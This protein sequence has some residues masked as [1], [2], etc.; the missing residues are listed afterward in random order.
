MASSDTGPTSWSHTFLRMVYAATHLPIQDQIIPKENAKPVISRLRG[1]LYL[2]LNQLQLAKQS[3]MEALAL[4]VRNFDV[5]LEL[6]NSMMTVEEE[7]HF[8]QNL[9]YRDQL[10][11]EDAAFNHDL[12]RISAARQLLADHYNLEENADMRFLDAERSFAA[13]DWDACYTITSSIL[14]EIPNHISALPLHLACL[15]QLPRL[16]SS[17][18]MLAHRL[19]REQPLSF[20][21]WYA[22]GLWYF[23]GHNWAE[24]RRYFA[25]SLSWVC[26]P[27][28]R[29]SAFTNA[30][31]LFVDGTSA[32]LPVMCIGMEYIQLNDMPMAL[33]A[34]STA[35]SYG[36]ED[37]L[38]FNEIGI[39]HFNQEQLLQQSYQYPLGLANL[40]LHAC[41]NLL[42]HG[43][44]SKKIQPGHRALKLRTV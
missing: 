14:R 37:P 25:A 13:S 17:L 39:V 36:V 1:I 20:V 38:L 8:I 30:H 41:R 11:S 16:A 32:Y 29:L 43:A 34:L 4:D 22:V 6:T 31:S 15:T 18:F 40:S 19:V 42:Q 21:S 33:N 35:L 23:M 24:A 28:P 27:V 44:L 10:H 2:R 9:S 3:F 26:H 12:H 7:W 5:F